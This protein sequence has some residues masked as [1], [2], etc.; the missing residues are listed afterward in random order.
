MYKIVERLGGG[1]EERLYDGGLQLGQALCDAHGWVRMLGMYV[2]VIGMGYVDRPMCKIVKRLGGGPKEEASIHNGGL[3]LWQALCGGGYT[4]WCMDRVGS[5][6]KARHSL[7]ELHL[8]KHNQH[9]LHNAWLRGY[10]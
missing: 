9:D 2:G 6:R 4:G 8:K 7:S 1:P 5:F 10:Q 3:Q